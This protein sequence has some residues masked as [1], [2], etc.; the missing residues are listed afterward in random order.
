MKRK[1]KIFAYILAVLSSI[2][3]VGCEKATMIEAAHISEITQAGSKN[4]GVRITYDQDRR[5]EGKIIDTQIKFSKKGDIVIWQEG[6]EQF[7]YTILDDD[8]WYS[9]TT[10]F[11]E[12]AGKDGQEIFERKDDAVAK[13]Y[14]FNSSQAQNVTLRVVVGDVETNSEQKG[15][16][17]VGSEPISN[18]FTLKIKK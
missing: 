10:I 14:L 9:M 12:V 5:L 17:L 13:V 18:Q 16:I 2:I 6:G 7:S 11:A 4:Y 3:F 8:T 15:E 1:L